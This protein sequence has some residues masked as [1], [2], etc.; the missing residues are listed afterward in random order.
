L[1]DINPIKMVEDSG[2]SV[3]TTTNDIVD[4]SSPKVNE[5]TVNNDEN[6]YSDKDYVAFDRT[7]ILKESTIDKYLKDY[8]SKSS[9]NYAQA[10][11]TYMSPYHFLELTTSSVIN[12]RNIERES[13]KF[14][15]ERFEEATQYQPIQLE[16]D[17]ETGEVIGHEGR[18]RMVALDGEGIYNVPVL[19]FDSS[20][21]YNKENL[22]GIELV[23][24]F[25]KY[26]TAMV[27]E[28]IPLSYA[29]RDLIVEKFGTKNSM[30][31][32]G[33]RLGLKQTLQ[34]SD[35]NS[36]SVYDIVGEKNRLLK[37]N[38]AFK[39]EVE[40]LKEALKLE[41]QVTHG[42][43]F[44]ENQLT[45]V[46]KH[47]LKISNS[48]Y[49]GKRLIAELKD[50]YSYIAQSKELT[51]EDLFSKCYTVA[52]DMVAD[53][54]PQVEIDYGH[55]Q[56]LKDIKET[57]IYLDEHQKAEAEY[58]FGK[59]WNRAFFGKVII[60]NDAKSSLD[61]KWQEW[62]E[63]YP[64]WFD[65][66]V[67]PNDQ[68][69]RLIE[70]VND[71]RDASEIVTEYDTEE[72]ARWL[73]NEIYN[74]YWNVSSIKTTADKYD[75]QMQ[76]L[77]WKH[78]QA[79][80]KLRSEYKERAEQKAKSAK[81][82]EQMYYGKK[83][84]E[85]DKE[86][87]RQKLA[88]DMYYGKIIH[89]LQVK[90]EQEA[91]RLKAY[92]KERLDSFKERAEQKARIQSI[93][94]NA[95]ILNEMLIKNSKDKHIPEAM[96]PVVEE[97]LQAI[98]FSSKRLLEGGEATQKDIALD[99]VFGHLKDMITDEV[100][101]VG[102]VLDEM[103]GS[104][105]DELTRELVKS[106]DDSM[107]DIEGNVFTLNEM[108]VEDLK[109]LD[110]IIKVMKQAVNRVNKFHIA[111]YNAGVMALGV[112][113]TSE[114]DTRKKLFK[115]NKKH[116]EKLKTHVFWNNL[117]PYY[118]FKHLGEASQ[119]I[120]T[121]LQ[122][123]QD[124]LAFLSR[125]VIDFAK[126]AYTEAEYKKWKDTFFDFEIP[127]QDGS[128]AKF[129][130]NVP[131]IMSL[132]CLVKQEDARKHILFGDENGEGKG[133]TIV[134]TEKTEAVRRNIRL[135]EANLKSIIDKLNETDK[136]GRAKEVADKLQEY[137]GTR[138]AELGN[139]ISMA[140]WGIKSFGIKDYFPIKVSDGSVPKKNDTPGIESTS[141]LE[142]LNMS[143]TK[144][145]NH[146]AKQSV[147]IGDIMDVFA[148]HMSN[149]VRYNAMALPILD[150][151]KWINCRGED[152]FGNEFSLQTSIKD[153]FG[154]H[155]WSYFNTF[156]K[157]ISG[158]TKKST[159]DKLA[160]KFFKNAKVAKVAGNLR[161]ALLQFTSFVRAGAVIDNKYLMK[162]LGHKPKIKMA[163][164]KCGIAQWKSQGYYDTDITRGLSDQIKHTTGIKDKIVDWS[165]KG[166]EWGDKI[167]WGYLWTACEL[168]IRDKRK[169]LTVGSDEFY[170]A[171]NE[172]L[173]D[174]IYRT[175][176]VDSIL[177]RSQM[178][179]SPDTWDKVL[180]MFGSE[181]ALSFNMAMD[182][183]VGYEL[184]KR[185][186][187]KKAAKEKNRKYRRKAIT[188]FI[189]TN[190]VTTILQSVFD[191]FRDYDEE[192][193]DEEYWTKLMLTNFLS[194][195]SVL[196]KLPYI[197]NISSI[198]QGFTPSRV[199]TDWM[200][201]AVKAGKEMYKLFTG[202]GSTEKAIKNALKVLSDST[203][204]AAYNVY[205]D[206]QAMYELFDD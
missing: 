182:V 122:D 66:D 146:F 138:G 34:Y 79:M 200:V 169:D 52:K 204:I 125:E 13:T 172:R 70:I 184:D 81:L 10:Y 155:A 177:T 156:L 113:S 144:S 68:V 129:S 54:K 131:Q 51:W 44:N 142:I 188:A 151:Y 187:G 16:I 8:A 76:M 206:I 41:K 93:T 6:Q 73:A 4:D 62:A 99:K 180:T 167:T 9:P 189:A 90:R 118:A 5:E 45:A 57:R 64:E 32:M 163:E 195:T 170:K 135:T 35:K 24:Q 183:F 143:F 80:D 149:M 193:K 23:G 46:A 97:L 2:K 18:H 190:V 55:K 69:S 127:K 197:S 137:M 110:T 174:V 140:R 134:E 203:G 85:K 96:K 38:E 91:D 133:I 30:Q 198:L 186:M 168:E 67:N 158:G 116:F 104:G 165:L 121:A 3:S 173:R 50:I 112:K 171:I 114:I 56:I 175:Q 47:L 78:R 19:L 58:L 126:G 49:S 48:E 191:A 27:D 77:K 201:S 150:M 17:H 160:V 185:S 92:G 53:A 157:D 161:V 42:N 7:A 196:N 202:E 109:K 106:V 88:D 95:R 65:A 20:N 178:M 136:V 148:N 94:G 39:D 61:Q 74:Q 60:A 117:N 145:R 14:E 101:E 147:E 75:K 29:N 100:K 152:A 26:N 31:K 128:T 59:H 102:G 159:R 108:S 176:V 139:E 119:K 71:M 98:D 82:L 105:I 36:S 111:Q 162:A 37:E 123:G 43:H 181:S 21:K 103:Y 115:D 86:I 153:T 11:I 84:L 25:N 72:Q 83:L 205:R 33:E 141:M 199:D 89:N 63:I 12:R 1:Y 154:D 124:K 192:D 40:R 166:A 15:K 87:E 107:K 194:N 28:A 164:E 132:Y 22:N 179:R 130:M 120:F